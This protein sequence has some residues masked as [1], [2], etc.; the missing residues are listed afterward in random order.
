M[1]AKAHVNPFGFNFASRRLWVSA[2]I[3]AFLL[4]ASAAGTFAFWPESTPPSTEM[5]AAI[6]IDL[7]P[8]MTSAPQ[9]MDAQPA[10]QEPEP[11]EEIIEPEPEPEPEPQ[12]AEVHLPKPVPVRKPKPPK[13][14]PEETEQKEPDEERSVARV[15][16]QAPVEQ[17]TTAPIDARANARAQAALLSYQQLLLAHL[18]RH[19]EYPRRARR[20]RME[21]VVQLRLKIDPQ[22][23][24]VSYSLN[25]PSDYAL[26]NE[27]VLEMVKR[28]DPMPAIPPEMD[29]TKVDFIVPVRFNL[30]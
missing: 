1:S 25:A 19:K 12:K 26:L 18:E 16:S 7:A 2:G 21:G 13:P 24:V 20:A 9:T 14:E 5:P 27:E 17:R 22:G 23:N 30:R 4:H 6:A 11:I 3:G 28:A 29:Q 10:P 15:S 8:M